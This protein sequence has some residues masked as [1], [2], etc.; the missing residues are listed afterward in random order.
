MK[1]LR[2]FGWS[3]IFVGFVLML[4][5]LHSLQQFTKNKEKIGKVE[6]FFKHNPLW[7]PLIK[8]FGGTP[9]EKLPEHDKPAMIVQTIGI[10]C[11][12]IGGVVVYVSR[13]KNK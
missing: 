4:F 11:M 3:F 5:A 12:V 9:Q 2:L 13:K 6:I 7:N 1:R 8:F 10:V